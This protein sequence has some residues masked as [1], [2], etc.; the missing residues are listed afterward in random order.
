MSARVGVNLLWLLPGQVGGSE[1]STVATLRAL[2]ELAPPDLAI[3]LFVLPPFAASYPDL[4]DAFPT[5]IAVGSGRS[6][7]ARIATESTWLAARTRG[8]DLVHHAGGTAPP[9]RTAPYVLTVHDLQPFEA[10]A[11]HGTTKRV[12]LRLAVPPSV[13]RARAV[14]VPSEFVR[15]SVLAHTAAEPSKVVSIPH[16]VTWP[17]AAALAPDEVRA[18]FDLPGSV[19]LYPAVTYPHKNHATLVEAFALVHADHP[20]TCLVLTGAPGAGEGALREQ[21][22]R[23]GL[24][25][26]VRRL[27]RVTAEEVAGLYGV[28]DLVAVPS[29]YEGFGLPAA[30]AM[31]AGVALVAADTTALPEVVG[32]AGWLVSP[33]APAEWADAIGTLLADPA[34]R[35]DLVERGRQRVGRYR[36][37]ANAAA[38]ADLY[39]GALASEESDER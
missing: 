38:F 16:G 35:A 37:D 3:E 10:Q 13:R 6:R 29:R 39:R 8:L 19:V 11:T 17:P 15:R 32:D 22:L 24:G 21:V 1:Q 2:R 27:G 18:R 14:A 4:V 30:E 25:E 23:L 20:E 5:Q 12:Y 36:W 28:A 34:A 26:R 33:D 9:R 7:P 31:A